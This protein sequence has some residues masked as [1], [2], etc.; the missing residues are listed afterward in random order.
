MFG[1]LFFSILLLITSWGA[2]AAQTATHISPLPC[3]ET[4]C[5]VV[6]KPAPWPTRPANGL[7]VFSG[8][9]LSLNLPSLPIRIAHNR[10]FLGFRLSNTAVVLF[11]DMQLNDMIG[12]DLGEEGTAV[13]EAVFEK[14]S[15]QAEDA[16]SGN[17][18]AVRQL[19]HFK[20][21]LSYH[22][23]YKS[24]R[25]ALVVYWGSTDKGW[26]AIAINQTYHR[27]FLEITSRGISEPEFKKIVASIRIR[28]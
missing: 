25:D 17:L 21:A 19:I 22:S 14:T 27:G 26:T 20:A 13:L 9:R 1:K 18:S 28:R 8:P 10:S 2:V 4:A 11:E 5:D 7:Q 16:F 3:P 6:A 12:S 24:K 23:L 15:K